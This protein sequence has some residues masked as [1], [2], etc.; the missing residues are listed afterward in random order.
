MDDKYK[1][2][3]NTNYVSSLTGASVAQ[4]NMWDRQGIVSPSILQAEGRGS[5]R[6]YSFKDIVEAKT[7]VYLRDNKTRLSEIRKAVDYL[8]NELDYSRPLSELVLLSD[9]KHIF[10]TPGNDINSISSQWLIANKNGQL[11]FTFIVP[12]GA[13]TKDITDKIIEYETRIDE[14][15]E[16]RKNGE[17]IPL[18]SIREK[19]FGIQDKPAKEGRRRRLA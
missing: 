12:L 8:K 15:E 13:I 18:E 19:Y 14:A 16:Q 2:A 3:F 5:I 4:L 11:V 10:C 6:L 17:L 9:G 7:V 1:I